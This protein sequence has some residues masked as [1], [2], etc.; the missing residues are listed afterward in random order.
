MLV[1]PHDGRIEK[2]DVQINALQALQEHQD[3]PP[4]AA[5]HPPG[6]AHVNDVPCPVLRGSIAP[7]RA[8]AQDRQ[9]PFQGLPIPDLGRPATPAVLGGQQAVDLCKLLVRQIIETIHGC[10]SGFI[11]P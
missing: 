3:M 8:G 5:L 10:S 9:D 4:H 6:P 7:R 2:D 1:G 11:D